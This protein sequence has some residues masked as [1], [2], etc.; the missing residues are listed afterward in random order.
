MSFNYNNLFEENRYYGVDQF[1]NSNRLVYG[2]ESD[3]HIKN[4][5]LVFNIGQSYDFKKNSNYAIQINQNDY[6]SDII[7]NGKL[8]YDQFEFN[9]D[10]RID[11][12]NK[13][14]KV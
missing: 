7:L 4:S 3:F 8:I 14:N 5:N 9:V 1:D 13:S 10:T 6:F 2:I 11:K 12:K